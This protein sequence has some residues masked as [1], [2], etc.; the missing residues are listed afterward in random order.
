M[1]LFT[2]KKTNAMKVFWDILVDQQLIPFGSI[3]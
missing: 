3:G 2:K 1:E